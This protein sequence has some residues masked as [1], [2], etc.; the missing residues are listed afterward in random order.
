MCYVI[1]V[2]IIRI[3]EEPYET[4][5]KKRERRSGENVLSKL[6]N[7]LRMEGICQHSGGNF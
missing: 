1:Y 7:E 2:D 3:V 4:K 5:K 6:R